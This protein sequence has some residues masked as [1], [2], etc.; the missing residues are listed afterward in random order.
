[1]CLNSKLSFLGNVFP[2]PPGMAEQVT[3][4]KCTPAP[5]NKLCGHHQACCLQPNTLQ[6]P[7]PVLSRVNRNESPQ[8]Q[9]GP[10]PE[11]CMEG[12]SQRGFLHGSAPPLALRV[13]TRQHLPPTT[14]KE[15]RALHSPFHWGRGLPL[16]ARKPSS[17]QW[18]PSSCI[19]HRSLSAPPATSLGCRGTGK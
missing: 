14:R 15:R 9:P 7:Q 16:P 5:Q 13:T 10:S 6:Q 1:M 4:G 8:V 17:A 12:L 18:Q 19:Y 2:T 3:L 11:P